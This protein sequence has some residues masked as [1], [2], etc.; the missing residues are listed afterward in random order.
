MY[1]QV[2]QNDDA[3]LWEQFTAFLLSSID[4]FE[5]MTNLKPGD[6]TYESDC[7][8]R[9]STR[10]EL[11]L[12]GLGDYIGVECKYFSKD[13]VSVKEINHFAGK[14]NFHDMKTGILFT[15]TPVSGWKNDQGER[16]GKLVQ[17]KIFNRNGI[18]I[19]DINIDDVDKIL[20]GK[21]LIE[22]LIEKYEVVRLGL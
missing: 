7:V 16:Y 10:S 1:N 11:F 5:P 3:K 8:I 18:V 13:S 6:G 9:N 22:M 17:T 19:F 12:C 4:G 2:T 14:L 21:N 15:K 20:E